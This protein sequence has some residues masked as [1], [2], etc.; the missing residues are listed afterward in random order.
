MAN[1]ESITMNVAQVALKD[2]RGNHYLMHCLADITA[3]GKV[4]RLDLFNICN[5]IFD[6]CAEEAIDAPAQIRILTEAYADMDKSAAFGDNEY[7][8]VL[9]RRGDEVG[10]SGWECYSVLS[11]DDEVRRTTKQEMQKPSTR[12]HYHHEAML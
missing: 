4:T 7:P 3:A 11:T 12:S 2:T 1:F 10:L 5:Y 6:I 9:I 8:L